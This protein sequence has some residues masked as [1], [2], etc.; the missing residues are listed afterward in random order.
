MKFSTL[1]HPRSPWPKV[2]AL[3]LLLAG[4]C[5]L[6]YVFTYNGTLVLDQGSH[7]YVLSDGSSAAIL[8]AIVLVFLGVVSSI[9]GGVRT[10]LY[11]Q[12]H[13]RYKKGWFTGHIE[14]RD[15]DEA[16]TQATGNA[17]RAV[18]GYNIWAYTLL[19][20]L[21]GLRIIPTDMFLVVVALT[22]AVVGML[23]TYAWHVRHIEFEE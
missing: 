15:D 11:T 18:Y 7:E 1:V 6:S 12:K 23:V 5:I 9:I 14:L 2:I 22:V 3:T 10:Y 21:F 8:T 17:A 19:I 4:V 20:I 13:P 16:I